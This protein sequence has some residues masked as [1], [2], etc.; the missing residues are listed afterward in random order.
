MSHGGEHDDVDSH[1]VSVD[2]ETQTLAANIPNHGSFGTVYDGKL[3]LEQ[4]GYMDAVVKVSV[5]ARGQ[6][7]PALSGD[8]LRFVWFRFERRVSHENTANSVIHA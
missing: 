3:A 1:G 8:T 6:S 4:G 2:W 5:A 7:S